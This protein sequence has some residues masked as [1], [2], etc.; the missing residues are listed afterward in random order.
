MLGTASRAVAEKLQAHGAGVRRH[1]VHHPARAGD[2]A[3][4]AFLLDAGQAAQELV[5]DVLAQAF[6]AKAG[7]G[8]VQPLGAQQ[9]CVPSASKYCSSKLA[10]PA[11][12]ILPR[13]WLRRVTSSHCGLGRDHAPAGQVVQRRAPQHGLFAARVHGNVAAN[14]TGLGTRS[15]PPRTRNRRARRHRPRAG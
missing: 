9:A 1:A 8:N 3:V 13:L 2:Q 6:F 14:A 12:W 4:A 5:G 11:S 15:G 7:A 10:T